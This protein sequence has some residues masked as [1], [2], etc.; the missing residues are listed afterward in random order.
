MN[1]RTVLN[2]LLRV[3]TGSVVATVAVAGVVAG[4]T[5]STSAPAPRPEVSTPA[6]STVS[7]DALHLAAARTYTRPG[8]EQKV[9]RRIN[10]VRHRHH[11]RSLSSAS[12]T[13]RVAGQWS[14]HLARTNSLYHQSMRSLLHRCNAHYVGETLGRGSVTPNR[15][16]RLWLNSPPHRHILLSKNPRRIGVG[17]TLKHGRWVTAANF[18]RF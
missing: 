1:L 15:L 16:V 4:P 6:S 2:P 5:T 17:S 9:I 7:S 8:Y 14:A 3:L 10:I 18:M 12:C 11:L 13:E